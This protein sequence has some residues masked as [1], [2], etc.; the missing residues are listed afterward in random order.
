MRV[1]LKLSV[2]GPPEH[3]RTPIPDL[4]LNRL[5][6][7]QLKRRGVELRMVLSGEKRASNRIID[8]PLLRAV[9]RARRWA[10]ELVSG[11][12][13]SVRE[14]A[15][16]DRVDVRSLRRLLPLGFLS[17]RLAEAIAEGHQPPALTVT[18]LTR[19]ADLPLLW[20]AQAQ[21]LG[22]ANSPAAVRQL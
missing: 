17:P 1:A 22:F 6:P 19:R 15:W 3:S 18:G 13:A 16:Q 8:L 20:M 9:A 11:S 14:L 12:V 7:I 4:T 5:I 2:V 21:T 10:D